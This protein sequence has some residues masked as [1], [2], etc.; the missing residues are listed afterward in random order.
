MIEDVSAP[1][2][3]TAWHDRPWPRALFTAIQFLTRLPVPG[4]QTRDL[5]TFPEDIRRGLVF[6]P[7]IGALVGGLTAIALVLLEIALPWPVAVIAALAVEARLTG[8]FHEDAVADFCDALGGGWTR[9]QVLEIMKDSRVGSYGALGLGLGVALRA[10]GLVALSSL[11]QAVVV[12]VV[13]GAIGR[14]VILFVMALVPPIAGR[15]GLSKDVGQ[16]A[17]WGKVLAGL[18]LV[19]PVLILGAAVDPVAMIGA[20]VV[21][22]VF[23]AWYRAML[24]R[25][26][27]GVTGDCLGFSA[28]AGIVVTTLAFARNT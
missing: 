4:G 3:P 22:A 16:Q 10:S 28:Y 1:V 24:L 12:L 19:S 5:T 23:L 15:D 6:F 14:L 7:L 27:G 2:H 26:L 18:A 13:A 20:T 8:A 17:G 25:R 9:E 21:L 11:S